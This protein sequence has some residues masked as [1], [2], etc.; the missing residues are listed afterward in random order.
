ML[1]HLA[2]D[3]EIKTT[4]SWILKED[5]KCMTEQMQIHWMLISKTP[6]STEEP[7]ELHPG[8]DRPVPTI[9]EEKNV[10]ASPRKSPATSYEVIRGRHLSM[11]FNTTTA[12]RT[13][14][15]ITF[16]KLFRVTTEHPSA[17][18]FSFRTTRVTTKQEKNLGKLERVLHTINRILRRDC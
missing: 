12:C 18:L 4:V 7:R 2:T 9:H 3:I 10:A 11:L 16:G 5:S 17:C 15:S 6:S 13:A 14:K 8:S 1:R